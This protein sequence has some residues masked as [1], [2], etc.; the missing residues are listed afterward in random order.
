M[1]IQRFV[2]P[3]ELACLLRDKIV[4]L[5]VVGRPK[6]RGSGQV[7]SI[8]TFFSEDPSSNP[9]DIK[10]SFLIYCVKDDNK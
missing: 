6:G 1:T 8:S 7:V 9:A 10:L 3:K 2:V 5:I 4:R